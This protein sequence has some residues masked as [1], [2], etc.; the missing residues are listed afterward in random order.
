MTFSGLCH[1]HKQLGYENC[2]AFYKVQMTVLFLFSVFKL[3]TTFRFSAV[4]LP[5]RRNRR[6]MVSLCNVCLSVFL[7]M[8]LSVVLVKFPRRLNFFSALLFDI[9][10]CSMPFWVLFRFWPKL[11]LLF[12]VFLTH[13]L[14]DTLYT[15]SCKAR[16]FLC[17]AAFLHEV[18]HA[19]YV[20]IDLVDKSFSKTCFKKEQFDSATFS[21]RSKKC[22]LPW[23][24]QNCTQCVQ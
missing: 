7:P 10:G 15:T 2:R 9:S 16:A 17:K 23:Y 3:Y 19:L 8:R 6:L 12:Q 1:L 14:L 13:L 24:L 21:F 11:I 22:K 18:K 20:L 4:F 5:C